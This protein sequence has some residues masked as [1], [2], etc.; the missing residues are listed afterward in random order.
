[1]SNL[2]PNAK[3]IRN[4]PKLG[5]PFSAITA[6]LMAMYGLFA[7]NPLIAYLG[8]HGVHTLALLGGLL[9]LA[10]I[11]IRRGNIKPWFIWTT[12]IMLSLSSIT[13]LYWGDARYLM[14]L[15]FFIFSL[16]LLQASD[17]RAIDIF[18]SVSSVLMILMVIGACIGFLFAL[19]GF[20]PLY[21]FPNPDGRTNYF[22]YTTLT[23]FI[24]GNIIRPAG[25]YD[26]PGTLSFIVC[27][28]AA[29]RHLRNR[30]KRFTWLLLGLGFITFSL[31]HLIYV[32]MHLMAERI[33]SRELLRIV[34]VIIAIVIALGAVGGYD[35]LDVM[36]LQR[37]TVNDAGA[38]AGDNRSNQM[39]NAINHLQANPASILFSADPLCRFDH[40]IC[41]KK[42]PSMG[43]NPLS[44]LV[45]LGL[46]VSWPYY[47]CLVLLFLAPLRGRGYFVAFGIGLLL[48]QRPYFDG[49]GY[50]L[51]VV[52]VLWV[53]YFKSEFSKELK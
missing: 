12:L 11:I 22:Y 3:P 29:L 39:F 16:Y 33:R 28:I 36:L 51:L 44:P 21:E 24:L 14:A 2:H 7:I 9:V 52:L 49:V 10:V 8:W 45:F 31:A 23:N 6:T 38:L 4:I 17:L 50:S 13:A 47:I 32:A 42:Y 46:F 40:D 5:V 19:A 34:S 26:E 35:I 18:I 30:D 53:S 15:I 27:A 25:I 43:E 37:L 20:Q 41:K 48:M 1:M